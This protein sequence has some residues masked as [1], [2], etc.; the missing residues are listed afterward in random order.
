MFIE[1]HGKTIKIRKIRELA[2]I[3]V[4]AL[5]VAVTAAISFYI[6]YKSTLEKNK[7]LQ[8]SL[9]TSKQQV[10]SLRHDKDILM[11]RMVV[12]ESRIETIFADT[13]EKSINKHSGKST[14]R[15]SFVK[16]E[17]NMADVKKNALSVKK[18]PEKKPILSTSIQ[19]QK[20]LIAA[21]K[22]FIFF[23]EPDSDALKVQFTI[24]K[25][26]PN[27]KSISGYI[28]VV[29]KNNELSQDQWL[30]LPSV[31]LISEKPSQTDKG[32]YFSITRFKTIKFKKKN[33]ADSN[34]FNN[35]T[36]F[37]YSKKGKLLLEKNFPLLI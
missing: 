12:A 33:Q 9:E 1:D 22:D 34:R 16:T 28:F 25:I 18:Q 6:F 2:L 30:T 15:S 35:A 14:D 17:H 24:K 11:A 29:L 8:N 21:I 23:C 19:S 26:D 3:S 13:Q 32:Q 5:V 31:P 36:V 27:S 4:F 20:P 37:V 10:I 7:T